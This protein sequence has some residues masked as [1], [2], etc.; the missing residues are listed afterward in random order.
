MPSIWLIACVRKCSKGNLV[1]VQLR[2]F[3]EIVDNPGLTSKVVSSK[4]FN[5]LNSLPDYVLSNRNIFLKLHFFSSY[6]LNLFQN[7]LMVLVVSKQDF[8]QVLSTISQNFLLLKGRW[9]INYFCFRD[10]CLMVEFYCFVILATF[11]QT[12]LL[13]W[14]IP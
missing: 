5:I 9:M 6:S 2:Y 11:L 13:S 12:I 8:P 1:I 4:V 7:Y 3:W 10:K 14:I